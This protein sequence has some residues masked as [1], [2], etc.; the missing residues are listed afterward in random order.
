MAALLRRHVPE[1]GDEAFTLCGA[2][3]A[4]TSAVWPLTRP[5]PSVLA[6]YEADPA[7]AVLRFEFTATMEY[8]VAT[9]IA[10]SIARAPSGDDVG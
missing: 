8:A 3:I 2:I 10:G 9:L 5:S 4:V 1:V 6:A 7:L